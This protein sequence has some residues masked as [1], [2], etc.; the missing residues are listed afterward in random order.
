MLQRI[1]HLRKCNI[2]AEA[3]LDDVRAF[4][5]PLE[6]KTFC[7]NSTLATGFST[8]SSTESVDFPL[9]AINGITGSGREKETCTQR[10]T[11]QSLSDYAQQD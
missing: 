11:K 1:A 10:F 3:I 7:G 6:V 5:S 4:T 2:S 8:E 9:M